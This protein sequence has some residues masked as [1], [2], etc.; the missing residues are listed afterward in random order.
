MLAPR[1][2][3]L[4]FALSA[5]ACGTRRDPDF[6]C[7]TEESCAATGTE[8][9]L[10]ACTDPAAPVC[11]DDGVLGAAR[12][13]TCIPDIGGTCSVQPDCTTAERPYCVD[14]RCVQCKVGDAA[15]D[16]T[17]TTPTCS[18]TTN[19]CVACGGA[20]DCIGEPGG[21]VCDPGTGACVECNDAA[22]CT[23]PSR[24]VCE[25]HA[26]R[27]C[28]LD[29]ECASLVCDRDSGACAPADQV[30]YVDG[31]AAPG[32][33]ACTRAAP[34][35]TITA[36]IAAAAGGDRT[37][38]VAAG[39]YAGA[40]AVTAGH[41][42]IHGAG[43]QTTTI[44]SAAAAT[45]AVTGATVDLEDV[46][47]TGQLN[48]TVGVTCTANGALRLRRAWIRDNTGGGVSVNACGFDAV[49][50]VITSNGGTGSSFGGALITA[51]TTAHPVRFEFNTVAFNTSGSLIKGVSCS[52]VPVGG[53]RIRSSV[54]WSEL[55]AGAVGSECVVERSIVSAAVTGTD[56]IVTA[57]PGL[58]AITG[59]P[60][61]GSAAI[62][63]GDPAS[64]V[65]ADID[66]VARGAAP[67]SGAYELP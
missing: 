65:T 37:I 17:G 64:T 63:H 9:G 46:T 31:A 42:T 29:D 25:A 3:L 5:V 16:C 14:N 61:A 27:G 57:S 47:V 50:T 54:V 19:L 4:V 18:P 49:N 55:G 33:T 24:P 45:V 28:A 62:D 51:L 11:D 52:A 58:T 10:T 48:T 44:T 13:R 21:A 66:G 59:R 43:Y 23:D 22:D 56:N 40:L 35:A 6:C 36:A 60:M 41:L 67:D 8:V 38:R 1:V 26:C 12:P 20:A 15:N 7:S 53:V 39:T 30:L 32:N 34:C 2:A